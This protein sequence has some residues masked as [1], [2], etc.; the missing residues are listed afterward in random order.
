MKR[1]QSHTRA[2]PLAVLVGIAAMLSFQ[3]SPATAVPPSL[4]P[5]ITE[6]PAD[7]STNAPATFEV[8][9]DPADPNQPAE[10]RCRV[11]GADPAGYQANCWTPE[12]GATATYIAQNVPNGSV[13]FQAQGKDSGAGYG[14]VASYTWTQNVPPPTDAPVFTETPDEVVTELPA[15]FA[16][17][18]GPG[19]TNGVA[20]FECRLDSDDPADFIPC[21]KASAAVS[22]STFDFGT[23]AYGRIGNG[24]HTLD[25]R[26]KT[27]SDTGPIA[28]HSWTNDIPVEINPSVE[29]SDAMITQWKGE[30]GQNLGRNSDNFN[31]VQ[32]AGDV[33]SD[34]RDDV[35]AGSANG[36]EVYLFYSTAQGLGDRYVTSFGANLGYAMKSA[37]GTGIYDVLGDVNGD[38]VPD[39]VVMVGP[40]AAVVYG[41]ADANTLS[42]CEPGTNQRRCVDLDNLTDDQGYYINGG[43]GSSVTAAG[44]FNGD[45]LGD[46]QVTRT[47]QGTTVIEGEARTGTVDPASLPA[48]EKFEII[49]SGFYGVL[50]NAIGDMNGDGKDEVY[51]ADPFSG[52][53]WVVYGR[54]F[55]S[56]DLDLASGFNEDE[57]IPVATSVFQFLTPTN[58]G[59]VNG[60]GRPDLT[61]S[62]AGAMSLV[63]TPELPTS[64]PLIPEDPSVTGGYGFLDPGSTNGIDET[65]TPANF[66]AG[67][68][69]GGDLNNDGIPDQVVGAQNSSFGALSD[70]GASYI[71][72]GQRPTP[73]SGQLEV[74]TDLTASGGVAILGEESRIF[75]GL[76]SGSDSL[77]DV[78]GDGVEDYAISDS[79]DQS[80]IGG[81]D[82]SGSVY[83]VSGGKILANSK[84]GPVTDIM[85][86]TATLN[87]SVTTS[88]RNTEVVFEHGTTEEYGETSAPIQVDGS[89]TGTPVSLELKGLEANTTYHYRTVTTNSLGLTH[90][91]DDQTFTTN[92]D[93]GPSPCD[94][95][96]GAAGCATYCQVNPT[97]MGCPDFDWCAANPGKCGKTTNAKLS[98]ISAPK[99]VKVKRGKKGK[100]AAILVNSGGQNANGVKVCVNAPKKFVKVK[101]CLKV[102]KLGSGATKTRTFKVKVKRKT[103]KGKKI[104]LKFTASGNGVAKKK[105]KARIA[106]R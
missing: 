13:T 23:R 34:G 93:G 88:G 76:G 51:N 42:K 45:G 79:G 9:P 58:V 66:G 14:P 11:A 2:V 4:P 18:A 102:G 46:F 90:Y 49:G 74:G 57:G 97:A 15:T 98:L 78:T 16:V 50:P 68:A 1:L 24:S 96:P 75:D 73:E 30:P 39:F 89:S 71:T 65:L 17:E 106:V 19:D 29:V 81:D 28:S 5:I 56:P 48:E 59:D 92:N 80:P 86:S 37:V 12:D 32:N 105:A 6:T 33:N 21:N 77:G 85:K 83:I 101:R 35:L 94:T 31:P 20:G 87:A 40:N 54:A 60:D 27:G 43:P 82:M 91:G 61:F 7:P 72:F 99:T 52:N 84:V 44:D 25:V 70:A 26:A 64:D 36:D 95:D 104:T 53:G 10:I 22:Q 63:Y 38:D 55:G 69:F 47:G 67:A 3:A 100:V 8:G 103:R 62:R 41:V